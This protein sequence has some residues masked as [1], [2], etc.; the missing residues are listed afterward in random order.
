MKRLAMLLA[1][2]LVGVTACGVSSKAAPADIKAYLLQQG[3]EVCNSGTSDSHFHGAGTSQWY[4][5]SKDCTESNQGVAVAY[6]PFD[7]TADRDAAMRSTLYL[8]R[9]L[10]NNVATLNYKNGLV[11]FSQIEDRDLTQDVVSKL[12]SAGAK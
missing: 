6:I 3:F 2:L 1:S 12:K 9:S 5:L 11:V 4:S 10:A 8:G 7:N